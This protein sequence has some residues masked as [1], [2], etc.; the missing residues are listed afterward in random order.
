MFPETVKEHI[1]CA[2]VMDLIRIEPVDMTFSVE[3]AEH[4]LPNKSRQLVENLVYNTKKYIVFSAAPLGQTGVGHINLR[5]IEFWKMLFSDYGFFE[6]NSDRLKDIF[7]NLSCRSKYVRVVTR[8]IHLFQ[9][10]V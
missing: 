4:I 8:N 9:K 1:E 7:R 2:N 5:K 10:D 3:V 6:Y